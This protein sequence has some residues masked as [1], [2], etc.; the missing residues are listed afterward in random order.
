MY[1]EPSSVFRYL[2][3]SAITCETSGWK[4]RKPSNSTPP[5]TYGTSTSLMAPVMARYEPK[6][7]QPAVNADGSDKASALVVGITATVVACVCSS[8]ASVYLE[9]I[10]VESKPSVWVR[11]AKPGP[12][13]HSAQLSQCIQCI[14]CTTAPW[15]PQVRNVQLCLFTIPIAV[16]TALRFAHHDAQL[17]TEPL[18]G[19]GGLVWAAIAM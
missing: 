12:T 8:V 4:A 15:V 1:G 13:D 16:A 11:A 17:Y 18:H 14:Q 10:L 9:K 7:A 5:G 3:P 2:S 19:F 6:K